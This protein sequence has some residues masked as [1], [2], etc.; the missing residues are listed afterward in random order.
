MDDYNTKQTYTIPQDSSLIN[1]IINNL[2]IKNFFSSSIINKQGYKEIPNVQSIRETIKNNTYTLK[3]GV[4]SN[5]FVLTLRVNSSGSYYCNYNSYLPIN[6]GIL[7]PDSRIAA[8][9]TGD[10]YLGDVD[11]MNYIYV[12]DIASQGGTDQWIIDV[13]GNAKFT[14][15][16]TKNA[17]TV[18]SDIRLKENVQPLHNRGYITPITYTIDGKEQIGFSAQDMKKMYPELVVEDKDKYLSIAYS[19]Y[20]AVLQ[21]QIIEQQVQIAELQEQIKK[22]TDKLNN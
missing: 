10:L 14:N 12:S 16:T 11:N 19:Q 2:G 17:P 15:L 3:F 4:Q 21:A 20:T 13:Y 5:D 6:G 9:T 7:E 22:I 8:D 18:S 1:L